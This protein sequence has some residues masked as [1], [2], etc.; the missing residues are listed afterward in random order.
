MLSRRPVEDSGLPD[1][2]ICLSFAGPGVLTITD[3]SF[4]LRVR[5]MPEDIKTAGKHD[6]TERADVP[7][8]L[9]LRVEGHEMDDDKLTN[10]LTH[11]EEVRQKNNDINL[12]LNAKTWLLALNFGLGHI[13]NRYFTNGREVSEDEYFAAALPYYSAKLR[14]RPVGSKSYE[15]HI[16]YVRCNCRLIYNQ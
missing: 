8:R 11:F 6:F 9:E 1:R 13:L 15:K 5:L 14:L 16:S 2:Q 3:D 10:V 7:E 12:H 4:Y